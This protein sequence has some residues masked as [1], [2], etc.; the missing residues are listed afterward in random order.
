MVAVEAAAS[1]LPVVGTRVGVLPDLGEG[2]LTVP[3]GDEAG[4][5]DAL[6]SVLDDP[7][8]AAA[9]G[10]AGR[11]AAEDRFDLDRT[12]AALLAEYETLVSR[13]RARGPDR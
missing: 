4:L 3:V 5:V 2:A 9:M 13:G 11:R 8:R 12:S 7:R 6:A 10:M 1:G